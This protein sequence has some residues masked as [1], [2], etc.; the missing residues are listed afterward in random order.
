M[1][2]RNQERWERA[3]SNIPAIV[4]LG[5]ALFGVFCVWPAFDRHAER[6]VLFHASLVLVPATIAV[7]AYLLIHAQ[8]RLTSAGAI[9]TFIALLLSAAELALAGYALL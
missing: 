4:A 3:P 2:D 8:Q 5:M 7:C 9:L 6:G 1:S